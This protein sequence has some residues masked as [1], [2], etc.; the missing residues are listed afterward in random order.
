VV[1]LLL[2]K[3]AQVNILGSPYRTGQRY[4]TVKVFEIIQ[5]LLDKGTDVNAQGGKF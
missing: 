4:E 5:L 3:G 2:D 1:E